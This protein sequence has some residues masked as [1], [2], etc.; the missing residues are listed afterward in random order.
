[1]GK[2]GGLTPKNWNSN[3]NEAKAARRAGLTTIIQEVKISNICFEETVDESDVGNERRGQPMTA[4]SAASSKSNEK[5]TNKTE[6]TRFVHLTLLTMLGEGNGDLL[7]PESRMPRIRRRSAADGL[8]AGFLR[9]HI[10]TMTAKRPSMLSTR[11]IISGD[12]V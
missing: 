5:G 1:M 4:A 2:D 8:S 7:S 9:K 6:I 3:N 10:F 11:D 12:G